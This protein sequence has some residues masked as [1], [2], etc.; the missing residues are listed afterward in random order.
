[1]SVTLRMSN[2]KYAGMV[3]TAP[4]GLWSQARA[5][6]RAG[7]GLFAA[8]LIGLAVPSAARADDPV[9]GEASLQV[10]NGFARLILKFTEDVG[11]E[12]TTAGSILLVRFDHAAY[13][14]ID[15]W[16][17]AAPDY[18]SG[19]RGD[20]DGSALRLSLSRKL[21][22]NTMVAGER[23][24]IDLLPDNWTG[25]PPNLPPEVVKELADRARAAERALRMQ[26]AENES[27]KRPPVRV[28]ALVQPTFVRFVFE[29]P[30][31]VGVSS[32][33][34]DQ[35]LTLMFNAPLTFDLA[36][37]K[38]AAP[39]NV[40]SITQ[41]MDPSKT[42]VDLNVIGDVD[43]HSFRED[44]NYNIDVAFLQQDK[45]KSA[46]LPE[47]APAAKPAAEKKGSSAEIVQPTSESIAREMKP[48]NRPEA[49]GAAA[50]QPAAPEVPSRA[51]PSMPKPDAAV[52]PRAEAPNAE[53]GKTEIARTETPK[54]ETKAEVA[55]TE[56][57][58][59][60]VAKSETAAS[61]A[62]K[63]EAA[64][65]KTA[66]ATPPSGRAD[67]GAPV[68]AVRD[69]DGLRL[70]FGFDQP[71]PAALFRRGDTV[72]L[73]F[74]SSKPIDVDPIRAKGGAIVGEVTRLPLDKGQAVRIRL[75]R[76]QMHALSSDDGKGKSWTLAFADKAANSQQ[77]L[78]V[79]RNITDPA[80]ANVMVPLGNPGPGLLHRLTDPDAGDTLLVVTAL[81][82]IRGFIKR[83][84]FVELS[85]LDS[86]H[87]VAIRPNSDDVAVELASDK[88]ILGKPG[89]L[90]L[91]SIGYSPER[92]SSA[93]RPMFDTDEWNKNRTGSFTAREDALVKASGNAEPEKRAEARLALARIY[94]ARGL[95]PEARGITNLMISDG[96]PRTDEI[97]MLTIHAVS[98]ILMGRPDQGA[99][100]LANSAIGN[101][102]D[103]QMWKGLAFARLGKWAD[104]REKLKNVEFAIAALP[105]ELQRVVTADAMKAALEVR[106]FAGA[107]KRRA[108]LDVIGVPPEMKPAVAVLRGRLAEAM[109]Q[110]KDALDDYRFAVQSKDRVA[111]AEG[112]L[113]EIKLL[114][115]RNEIKPQDAVNELETLQAIWRGD[116]IEVQT[117][118]MLSQL[119]SETGRYLD[120]LGAARTATRLMPNS[121]YARQAQ[122]AA[123]E[124]FSQLFLGGKA[125]DMPPVD[126]LTVFYEFRELTPIGRRGDE[127]IRRLSD[128]LVGIDLLDQA[129]ELLQYQIDKRLEG[130]ARA[131]VAARLA[132]VYL[133]NRKPSRAIE[134]LNTTR[135]ADL[136]GELRTQRLLLEARAQSDIGRHDL[137][138]D[139]ISNINGREAIRL[140]SDIYWVSRH[141]REA[142]EQIELYYGDRWR[143]FRPLNPSE[144]GDIIRAVVG[145]ALAEDA[146]GLGRFREKYAP[147]MTGEADKISFDVASR[148][149]T[150]TGDEFTAIAKMAA[151]VDTLDGFLRDMKARF[152]DATSRSPDAMKDARGSA[153][154]SA[155]AETDATGALPR[156]IG[157]K[158]A[159]AA[160]R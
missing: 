17:E 109:A 64:V 93:V 135:I 98:S 11:A 105:I 46:V 83:Q 101:G 143:D 61:E 119:Y 120:S 118:Q 100:D 127:M 22:V 49:A 152:P 51:Q 112:K 110:E 87:G 31:G 124:L 45:P 16:T 62:A 32:V 56:S 150:G 111:A 117:L 69:S 85:L 102:S 134:A 141:W 35:K 113:L 99:K 67:T 122:D 89:G 107:A 50:P 158:Q 53:P 41:K 77:P 95:Y 27:K 108:E 157:L 114:Q 96:D 132:M 130:A 3:R 48:E 42:V 37:A 65:A 84:D 104:A 68:D 90:T 5:C 55:K 126:A 156:I 94:M 74:D 149:A 63:S 92:A 12:V 91:S 72:W 59:T 70:T 15:R 47:V 28:R 38:I 39:P 144:R 147:L 148:P 71:T 142:S 80:L 139:I 121:E 73:V 66:P 33:L 14:P 128:R 44:K 129:A 106:D 155:K 76:P 137:A 88:I 136:S 115:K 145:Y 133:M 43:V 154:D 29:M 79:M 151:S 153:K 82:P 97:G 1:M 78:T 2:W 26:R 81:P 146:I 60:E 20:P 30:D 116:A 54:T 86:F 123:S 75:N 36:D 10:T 125:D 8:V 25:P 18:I 131:Q 159:D 140:R 7:I 160:A 6:A 58:K 21:R 103:S 23:V 19:A 24:F 9:K 13:V 57:T 40:A 52:E 4:V 34:N 138:L